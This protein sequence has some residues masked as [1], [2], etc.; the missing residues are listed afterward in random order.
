MCI[1]IGSCNGP[2]KTPKPKANGD[3]FFGIFYKFANRAGPNIYNS[4]FDG[5]LI[6]IFSGVCVPSVFL[7]RFSFGEIELVHCFWNVMCLKE[8]QPQSTQDT[9]TSN[10][11]IWLPKDTKMC[12]CSILKKIIFTFPC[13]SKDTHDTNGYSKHCHCHH[14]TWMALKVKV[15]HDQSITSSEI[16]WYNQFDDRVRTFVLDFFFCMPSW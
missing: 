16:H 5:F 3:S 9:T 10:K 15:L 14:S 1:Y 12:R 2:G 11:L 6:R 8:R 7:I 13:L 4:T